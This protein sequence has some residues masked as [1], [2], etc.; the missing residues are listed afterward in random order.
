MDESRTSADSSCCVA[1]SALV[2]KLSAKIIQKV[3]IMFALFKPVLI[4]SA[5]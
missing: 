1:L 5:E 3:T 2:L 4:F